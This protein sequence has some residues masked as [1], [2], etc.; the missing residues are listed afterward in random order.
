MDYAIYDTQTF[1]GDT[2]PG[3]R[4][5]AV[6]GSAVVLV[7]VVLGFSA[8]AKKDARATP[9]LRVIHASPLAVRGAHFQGRE[10]V[11]LTTGAK[12]VRAKASGD[13]T[14]VVT[15]RGATRCDSVRVLARGSAGS[16]AVLKVLP[17][18]ECLPARVGG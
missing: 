11:R 5:A 1:F 4:K 2:G 18:P 9:S 3:M 17:S 10:R 8:L 13:G 12:T 15:I 14:F 7:A 16:Y 6:A